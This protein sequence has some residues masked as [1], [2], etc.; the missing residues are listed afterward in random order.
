MFLI[1]NILKNCLTKLNLKRKKHNLKRNKFFTYT[2]V[3]I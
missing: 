3:N 1:I 2:L